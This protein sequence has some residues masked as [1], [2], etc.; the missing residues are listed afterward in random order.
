MSLKHRLKAK[1]KSKHRFGL[2]AVVFF[3]LTLGLWARAFWIQIWWAPEI[4]ARFSN[5]YFV[6]KKVQGYRGK[7]LDRN[8]VVLAQSVQ[9]FSVFARP[10]EVKSASSVAKQL[11]RILELDSKEV[12]EKLQKKNS[13]VWIKR[14]ISDAKAAQIK[15]IFLPESGIYLTTEFT[16]VYPQGHLL[17]QVLGFTNIDGEGLEG[18]E[19]SFDKVL[20]GKEKQ[21]VAFQDG[22]GRLIKYTFLSPLLAGKDLVLT[23]DT[24]V[25]AF[26]EDILEKS[27]QKFQARHG[28][29]IVVEVDNGEVLAL[30]NYP[31]FNPNLFY[32]S[33][34]QERRNRAALDLFE[35]GSTA[36]P[37]LL[38]AALEKK[39]VK[40]KSIYFCEQGKWKLDN[41]V[42]EDTHPYGWLP[43]NKILRYSSNIGAGK[44]AL[45]LGAE[46]YYRFLAEFGFKDKVDIP[47]PGLSESLLRPPYKWN[48]VD[49]ASAAF[50]QGWATTGLHLVQAYLAIARKGEFVPL[51]LLRSPTVEQEKGRRIFSVQTGKQ[52]LDMLWEVVNQE[53]TG[54]LSKLEEVELG[55]KTG[56][57]QKADLKQG[58]YKEGVYTSS[59]VGLL[60]ARNPKYVVFLL[61]DEPRKG[62][63]GGVV[64]GPGVKEMSLRLLSVDHSLLPSTTVPAKT[65]H[66]FSQEIKKEVVWKNRLPDLRGQSV[67]RAMDVLISQGLI[68][69]LKGQGLVVRGQ[70]PAPGVELKKNMQVELLLGES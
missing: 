58:G 19:K 11:A 33:T 36:K 7:I 45:E 60:P 51:K 35:P 69:Q 55:G 15:K 12:L 24:R 64:A 3:L 26:A 39:V 32:L 49:L 68:P 38:A 44:I 40:P 59:F 56:T 63:Y 14:K 13:F 53:G 29:L 62:H 17:G 8:G 42:I 10:Y 22:K 25:Q 23:I 37:F 21:F 6:E 1:D 65:K 57:A 30:A 34:P 41:I 52:L 27:V 5:Y 16:R 20:Q 70:K 61:L 28:Q 31:F 48:R 43:V 4:K 54:K 67:R 46:N 47:L 66:V 18:L 9:T 50:G 2:V